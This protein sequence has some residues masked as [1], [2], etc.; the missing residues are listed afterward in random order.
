MDQRLYDFLT[1]PRRIERRIQSKLAEIDA[2]RSCLLPAAIR[3]DADRV[4]TSPDDPVSR[5]EAEIDELTREVVRLSA[6]KETAVRE[7]RDTIA[8]LP[9]ELERTVLALRWIG[10][11]RL[12]D[13]AMTVQYSI[14][15]TYR[16][17][18]RAES[19]LLNKLA[20]MAQPDVI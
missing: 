18:H 3:Y 15:S 17:M 5:I 4:Q 20:H 6:E 11:R 14:R 19:S 9:D 2:L 16:I 7:L 1:K 12:E 13:I 8:D 10:Y